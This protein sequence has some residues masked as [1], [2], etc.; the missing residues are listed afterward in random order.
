MSNV[1]GGQRSRQQQQVVVV[2]MWLC[3]HQSKGSKCRCMC[4]CVREPKLRFA[5][6]R[7]YIKHTCAISLPMYIDLT[8]ISSYCGTYSLNVICEMN[9][10][11][12]NMIFS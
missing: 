3:G 7:C 4:V 11:D 6:R 12:K 9:I 8:Y 5:V 1:G 10:I 2:V